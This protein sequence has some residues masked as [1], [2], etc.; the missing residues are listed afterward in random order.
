ML[1]MNLMIHFGEKPDIST[2]RNKELHMWN[3]LE[4]VMLKMNLMIHFGEKPDIS[5]FRSKEL[6]MWNLLEKV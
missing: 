2:F 1:R 4:M 6:H 5:T 3:L